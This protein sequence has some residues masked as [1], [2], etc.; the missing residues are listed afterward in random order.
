[1]L[2][3]VSNGEI[4]DKLTILK[5][6]KNNILDKEKLVNIN[7]EYNYLYDIVFNNLKISEED[8]YELLLINKQLWDIEDK[9]RDKERNKEFDSH[10]IELAR[11]VYIINDKRSELKKLINLKTKSTF[12][13]EKSY[14]KY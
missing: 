4:V 14:E 2:I 12:V 5:I 13:E 1:M 10:F 6:K 3:E 7:K 9:I 8:Y 11:L